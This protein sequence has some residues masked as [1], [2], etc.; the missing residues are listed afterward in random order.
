MSKK[1]L[2]VGG[3]AGG[4]TTVARLRRLDENLEIILF[5]RGEYI[6]FAN[7]GLPYYIGGTIEERDALLVQTPESMEKRFNI[8]VRIKNEVI[9]ILKD[10]KKI[11][12]KDLSTG[13]IYEE[14]YD[15]LVLSPGSTPLRPPIPG[16][17][18]PNIFS[19]WNIP[20]TD[21]IYGFIKENCPKKAVVVG[22]GFIGLEMAE[23]LHELGIEV[24]IVEMLNQVMAPLDFEMAEIIHEHIKSKGGNLYLGDG[25]QTFDY[26]DGKTTIT[27]QSGKTIE[28]DLVILSIGIRPNGELAKDAGLEVNQRG[29]IVVDKNLRTSDKNIFAIGDAI[30]VIDFVNKTKTMVPLAG[31]ANK[32]GRIVAN[33]IVGRKEEYKGTQ[34]TSVAKVFDMTVAS[35]GNNEKTLNK[36][37][38]EY[39]KDYLISFIHAKSHAGY[40][41]EALPITIKLIF[42]LEGKILGAQSVGY[43]GVDKRIDVIATAIRFGGTIYDLKELEL[44]YA[45]PYSSAK[46]PVNMAGYVAENILNKDVD[47]IFWNELDDLDRE[48]SI[49]LDVTDPEEREMGYVEGSINIPLNDLRDRLDELDKDKLI[50]PYCGIGIRGYIASRILVQNGFKAKNFAGGFMTYGNLFCK[51][52]ND[53]GGRIQSENIEYTDHGEIKVIGNEDD[54]RKTLKINI[55]ELTCP[56]PSKEINETIEKIDDG[57]ILEILSSDPNFSERMK[58]WCSN[59]RNTF[60]K[61]ERVDKGFLVTVKKGLNK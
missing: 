52:E 60:V 8:D 28:T 34:G 11:E 33:N 57:D 15:Y 1:V 18:S 61:G 31:P 54:S 13:K 14:S 6:S 49:I 25:V 55:S 7:C 4:A 56:T 24:S 46:D 17:D 5:E 16:I 51:D 36:L 41:P 29:G 44:A 39:G 12:V 26:K 10:E 3:V 21:A 20:D 53:C 38:K 40:Y 50:V 32:Q 45:P 42:D 19:L 35:T 27:L 43:D 22:G 37:G 2:V 48:N 30:E 59:T 9:K 47:T 23:N 58:T